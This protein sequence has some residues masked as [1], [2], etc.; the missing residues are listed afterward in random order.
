M[1]D[2]IYGIWKSRFFWLHLVKAELRVKYRR[3]I[4]GMAWSF[5]HPLLLTFLLAIVFGTIFNSSFFDLAPFIYSGL[6]M[7]EFITGSIVQGSSSI[8]NAEAYIGQFKHPL[9]IYTLKQ[10]LVVLVN[11]MIAGIG[12]MIWCWIKEP[13]TIIPTIMA[14]PFSLVFL[15]FL[16]WSLATV[17]GFINTK[18]RDFQQLLVLILQAIYFVSPVYFEPK[19]FINAGLPGLVEYNPVTHILNLVRA[20]LMLGQFPSIADYLY[21]LGV[22]TVMV[23]VS[24]YKIRK[25]EKELIFYL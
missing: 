1:K 2:Y 25:E 7:W 14:L 11:F 8:I 18:Y 4:L 17:A 24:S 23:M 13:S 12:L 20:P 3:S 15:F 19:I 10:S 5:L 21:T 6:I 16:S 22:I 9:S